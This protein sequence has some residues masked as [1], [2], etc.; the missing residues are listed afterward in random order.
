VINILS[1]PYWEN[2][3]TQY[4]RIAAQPKR[5]EA[6]RVLSVSTSTLQPPIR[7]LLLSG[8]LLVESHLVPAMTSS[9]SLRDLYNAPSTSWNF[10]QPMPSAGPSK[11][12]G[13]APAWSTRPSNNPIFDLAPVLDYGGGSHSTT[14]KAMLKALI[15]SAFLQYTTTA[16]A[17]PWEVGKVLLQIQWIPNNPEQDVE[18]DETE[19]YADQESVSGLFSFV[20][21]FE[22]MTWTGMGR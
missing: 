9:A 14:T 18:E 15:S 1:S 10:N 13:S 3:I 7:S 12:S 21:G 6:E 16:I 22:L 2:W 20:V 8:I 5:I 4:L 11:L 19:Q 17:M